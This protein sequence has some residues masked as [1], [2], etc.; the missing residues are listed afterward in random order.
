MRVSKKITDEIT[1]S[2]RAIR[3]S[4]E[5]RMRVFSAIWEKGNEKDL[6]VELVFCLL[7]PQSGARRCWRAV[8]TLVQKGFLFDGGFS[9]ICSELNIVRFKNN[10]T[11]YILEARAKFWDRGS[12][13]MRDVLRRAGNT[14]R[15][16][17]CLS[18]T[19]RGMGLKEASHYLRNI[20][21]GG[22]IAILDR[23]VLRSMLLMGL[24][25]TIPRTLTRRIYLDMENRLR[26]YARHVA[27]PL[28]HLDFVL[29]FRETGDLF[30]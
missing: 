22:D 30:K 14:Q 18:K 19:V 27:I 2:H 7:T 13:S 24:I 20:G 16:R 11:R 10:K 8:E 3:E 15:M 12:C 4:I 25:D 29:W 17:E 6:F 28:G 9:E 23:H 5:A 21:L 26:A 1:A